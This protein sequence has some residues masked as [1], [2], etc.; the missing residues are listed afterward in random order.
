[1]LRLTCFCSEQTVQEQEEPN[2]AAGRGESYKNVSEEK[3]S[4]FFWRPKN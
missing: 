1:M 3:Y 2:P 4:D